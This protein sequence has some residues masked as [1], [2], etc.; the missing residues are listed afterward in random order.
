MQPIIYYYN[1]HQCWQAYWANDMCEQLSE[2]VEA[3]SKDEALIKLGEIKRA[4]LAK[5][6][7]IVWYG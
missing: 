2:T 7:G 6:D 3:S 5:I 1:V 4:T